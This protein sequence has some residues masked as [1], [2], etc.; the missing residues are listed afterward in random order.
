MEEVYRERGEEREKTNIR[1]KERKKERKNKERR[2]RRRRQEEEEE[3]EEEEYQYEEGWMEERQ[4]ETSRCHCFFC[5]SF[6]STWRL[7]AGYATSKSVITSRLPTWQNSRTIESIGR[8]ITDTVRNGN[9][10][11]LWSEQV[12]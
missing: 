11:K 3:E 6:L 1:N 2:G 9:L 5:R 7:S 8:H 12:T 4:G 10:S